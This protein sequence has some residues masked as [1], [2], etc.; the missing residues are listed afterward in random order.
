MSAIGKKW[1][2]T[3]C[4]GN[5]PDQ[6]EIDQFRRWF[7]RNDAHPIAYTKES[8][9]EVVW[10]FADDP[11]GVTVQQ[12]IDDKVAAER[13]ALECKNTIDALVMMAEA[14]DLPAIKRFLGVKDG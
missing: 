2:I 5:H 6:E 4:S 3:D 8:C 13:L 10:R 1:I 9:G 12:A 11:S 7:T 14:D